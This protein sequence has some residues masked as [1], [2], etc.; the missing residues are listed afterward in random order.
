MGIHNL[1]TQGGNT[2]SRTATIPIIARLKV[3]MPGAVDETRRRSS[4]RLRP[5]RIRG[6]QAVSGE[7]FR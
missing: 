2:I 3:G 1:R 7:N 5:T 4:G 6:F